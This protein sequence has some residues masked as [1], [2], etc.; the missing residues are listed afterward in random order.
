MS[1]HPNHPSAAWTVPL[2]VIM[3]ATIIVGLVMM[4]VTLMLH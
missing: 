1:L 4:L 2:H 3:W